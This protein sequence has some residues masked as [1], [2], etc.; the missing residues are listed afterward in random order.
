MTEGLTQLL[1]DWSVTL[2]DD[3]VELL[4]GMLKVNARERL[5]T[6]EIRNHPWFLQEP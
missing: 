2:S 4:Q 1:S 5:T 3:A 6:E